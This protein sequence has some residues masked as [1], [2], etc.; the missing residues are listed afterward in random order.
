MQTLDLNGA[1]ECLKCDP[2]TVRGL[3][4]SGEIPAAKVG[5]AWVFV[6]V[7]L[8]EWIRSKYTTRKPAPSKTTPLPSLHGPRSKHNGSSE[9]EEALGLPLRR[10]KSAPKSAEH[11]AG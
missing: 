3:A 6:D 5:R 10:K 11:N 2:E 7:D 1:A 9:F 4:A 8:I